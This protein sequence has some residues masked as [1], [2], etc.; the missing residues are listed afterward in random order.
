MSTCGTDCS[1]NRTITNEEAQ[2]KSQT[3]GET[4]NVAKQ[5]TR[6]DVEVKEYNQA[7]ENLN[8]RT[9]FTNDI[10][11]TPILVGLKGPRVKLKNVTGEHIHHVSNFHWAIKMI[12]MNPITEPLL[13]RDTRRVSTII[14]VQF[15]AKKY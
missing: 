4:K 12:L 9:H 3:I 14:V 2:K 8:F 7:F 11:E 10:N 1:E 5:G 6:K 13:C 15:T